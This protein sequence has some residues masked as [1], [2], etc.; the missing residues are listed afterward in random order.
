[1]GSNAVS[2]SQTTNRILWQ[3]KAFPVLIFPC[4]YFFQRIALIEFLTV[5][6]VRCAP[7]E[8]VAEQFVK[9]MGISER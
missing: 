2:Q 6:I 4:R 1:M 8:T 5:V 9:V 7:D 3:E